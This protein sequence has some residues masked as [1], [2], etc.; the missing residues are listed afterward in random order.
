MVSITQRTS[1]ALYSDPTSHYSHRLRIVLEEKGLTTEVIDMDPEN[2]DKEILEINPSAT[3]PVLIDRDICLYEPSVLMEYLE[4][5][6][7]HPPL[8]PVYP[9]IKARSRLFI[10]RLEEEWC[11]SLNAL[12]SATLSKDKISKTRKE[13]RAKIISAAAIFNENNFFMSDD[14]S[15]VDCCVAP[16]LW[17]LPSVGVDLSNDRKSKPI[18][19]YMERVFSRPSFKASL[20]EL[21]SE[22]RDVL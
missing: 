11:S 5:R 4:E 1:M 7:P 17:R 19:S 9:V 18:Y 10:M 21:E 16:I 12:T 6:F 3:L 14:F 22:M 2:I 8:M 20:S 13:L 15:L